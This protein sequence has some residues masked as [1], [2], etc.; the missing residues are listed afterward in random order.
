MGGRGG[1]ACVRVRVC[2][3]ACVYGHTGEQHLYVLFCLRAAS[4]VL[5]PELHC[6]YPKPPQTKHHSST[7]QALSFNNMVGGPIP[8]SMS[9]LTE[10]QDLDLEG[11]KHQPTG[12]NFR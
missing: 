11:T 3:H 7:R 9:K 6:P 12:N 8:A 4:V 2:M 1:G 5:Y 10:L